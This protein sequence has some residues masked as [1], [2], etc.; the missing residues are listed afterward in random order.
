MKANPKPKISIIAAHGRNRELGKNNKLLWHI[1]SDLKRFKSLTE[2]H[3]IIM[4]Q[5]TYESIGR[6]LPERLNIV[7]SKD[8]KLEIPDIA[9]CNSINEAITLANDFGGDEIFIIGGGSVYA[10]TIDL[11]D[12]L[13]LTQVDAEFEADTF[14]PDYSEFKKIIFEKKESDE[15]YQYK[16]LELEK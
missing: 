15:N 6:P 16:F 10:Q 2:N 4:G 13:Y 7:L 9:V 11:A 12:K 14:F 8:L 1:S 5:K 3:A